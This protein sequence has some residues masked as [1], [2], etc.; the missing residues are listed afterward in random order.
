MLLNND[1]MFIK[2][3]IIYNSLCSVLV[4]KYGK[5]DTFFLHVPNHV[6]KQFLLWKH[7]QYATISLISPQQYNA[8]R[9][10]W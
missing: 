1:N 10:N 8:M 9:E 6:Q 7:A 2:W 5:I 3:N 4:F